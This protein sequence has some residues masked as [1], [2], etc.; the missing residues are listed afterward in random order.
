M[1][2][3]LILFCFC[4]LVSACG[5]DNPEGGSGPKLPV[6]IVG[7]VAGTDGTLIA[8]VVVSDGL[9]CVK[10][11]ASGYFE[12]R[13]DLTNTEYVTVSTPAGW[14]APVTSGQAVFWKYLKDCTLFDVYTGSRVAPGMKSVAFSLTMRSDEQTLTDEHA[15]ETVAAVLKAL[16]DSY[17][18]VIR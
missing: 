13:S 8:D 12:L 10:T 14:A 18:A 3:F 11:D 5:K 1:K 2:R 7:T 15:E 17:G 4:A 6:S 9:N 16:T